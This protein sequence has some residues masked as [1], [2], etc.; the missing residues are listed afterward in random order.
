MFRFRTKTPFLR[1]KEVHRYISLSHI[2]FN[3]YLNQYKENLL[4]SLHLVFNMLYY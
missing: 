3:Y 4:T 1:Y 2:L